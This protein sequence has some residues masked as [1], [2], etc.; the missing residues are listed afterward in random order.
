MARWQHIEWLSLSSKGF[1]LTPIQLIWRDSTGGIWRRSWEAAAWVIAGRREAI[2]NAAAACVADRC[3]LEEP[4]AVERSQQVLL[5]AFSHLLLR[6]SPA[7]AGKLGRCLFLLPDLR[8]LTA[9]YKEE[10]KKFST[11][12]NDKVHIPPLFY[13]MWCVWAGSPNVP[14]P[15][16]CSQFY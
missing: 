16:S 4:G 12:W 3:S 6:N 11:D 13:E 5:R 15:Q 8:S 10:E 14:P 7:D 2:V 9:A 1:D